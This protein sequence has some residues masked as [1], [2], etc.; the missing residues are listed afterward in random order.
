MWRWVLVGQLWRGTE[1]LGELSIDKECS[2]L[3]DRVCYGMGGQLRSGGDRLVM[4]WQL[5][6]VKVCRG[7]SGSSLLSYGSAAK[8]WIG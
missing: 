3:A 5:W 2:G 8:A 7:Q 6:I 4:D 1:C